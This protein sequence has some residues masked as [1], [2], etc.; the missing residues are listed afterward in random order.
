MATSP[1][2]IVDDDAI[3]LDAWLRNRN[4]GGDDTPPRALFPGLVLVAEWGWA[5]DDANSCH[6]AELCEQLSSMSGGSF[7]IYPASAT[8]VTIATLSSFKKANAPRACIG[9]ELDAVF[10]EAWAVAISKSVSE[11]SFTAFE[12]EAYQ[13]ELSP[14]AVFLHFRDSSG[15]I[16]RLRN[17]VRQARDSDPVLAALDINPE[18]SGRI[19]Q[20]VHLPNIVHASFARC[21]GVSKMQGPENQPEELFEELRKN[22][23]PFRIK[24]RT[25][26]LANECSPYM[27]Q[28]REEGTL[29]SFAL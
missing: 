3:L 21:I 29:R 1:D 2:C 26:T 20:S 24:I 7:Y 8:H 27:H 12:L 5:M 11:S 25:L 4:E 28:L 23:V 17:I 14:G 18:F 15:T 22:F 9:P 19:R 16:D 10:V 13:L 6:Y